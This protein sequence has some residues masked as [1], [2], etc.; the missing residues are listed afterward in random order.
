MT[1]PIPKLPA[2]DD[3]LAEFEDPSGLPEFCERVPG[4]SCTTINVPS[5]QSKEAWHNFLHLLS[6]ADGIVVLRPSCTPDFDVDSHFIGDVLAEALQVVES[7]PLPIICICKGPIQSTMMMLPAISSVVLASNDASFG[8]ASWSQD[9]AP[10][11]QVRPSDLRSQGISHEFAFPMTLKDQ[12]VRSSMCRRIEENKL[13]RILLSGQVM[14]AVEAQRVG[15]VDF[16]G[17]KEDVEN[18]LAR[19]V[20]RR[21]APKVKTVNKEGYLRYLAAKEA[22]EDAIEE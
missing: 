1:A 4:L 2:Q 19:L 16:V 6:I 20:Y 9:D 11:S 5:T 7:R 8:F 14:D 18:E 22:A 3:I 21:C 13:M 17:T 12:V 15:L 10:G